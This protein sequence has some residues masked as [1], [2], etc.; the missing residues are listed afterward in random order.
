MRPV[1]RNTNLALV[2]SAR[3]ALESEGIPAVTSNA[4]A[5][6]LPFNLVTVAVVSDADFDRAVA[7]VGALQRDIVSVEGVRPRHSPGP[8]T[9]LATSALAGVAGGFWAAL[10][11]RA[12]GVSAAIAAGV[13]GTIMAVVVAL[14]MARQRRAD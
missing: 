4:Y 9:R 6:G 12:L 3:L 11:A 14:L 2:E 10:V 13:A 7:I 5:A 1:F 8:V